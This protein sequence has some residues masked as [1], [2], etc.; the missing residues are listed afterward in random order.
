M[1]GCQICLLDKY[2]Q[3]KLSISK[4]R[5]HFHISYP[6]P[7]SFLL[8]MTDCQS[9]KSPKMESQ[10]STSTPETATQDPPQPLATDQ[11]PQP[12]N[13]LTD[14]RSFVMQ[15]MQDKADTSMT[16]DIF[17]NNHPEL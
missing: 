10:T 14:F 9:L 12:K 1:F 7:I 13:T 17:M 5:Y 8:P 16:E 4:E 3:N 2:F 15:K 11:D 6:F